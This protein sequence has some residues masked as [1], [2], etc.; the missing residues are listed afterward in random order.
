MAFD[1]MPVIVCPMTAAVPSAIIL[2]FIAT[3]PSPF[4]TLKTP[5]VVRPE[6]L[7]ALE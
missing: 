5:L 2:S 3:V 1:R 4:V 6:N 7:R